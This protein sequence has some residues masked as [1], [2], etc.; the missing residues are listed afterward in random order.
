M[1]NSDQVKSLQKRAGIPVKE[2]M[3]GYKVEE[4][5]KPIHGYDNLLNAANSAR[6]ARESINALI[7][8]RKFNEKHKAKLQKYLQP[9]QDV[10]SE[11]TNIASTG[12]K[13]QDKTLKP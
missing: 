12:A 6:A 4:R 2:E 13:K 11:L 8:D 1:K 9:L 10:Q 3:A 7:A 5:A